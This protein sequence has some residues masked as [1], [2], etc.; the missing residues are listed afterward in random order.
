MPLLRWMGSF[1]EALR[2]SPVRLRRAVAML[3]QVDD[4]LYELGV[5]AERR[6]GPSRSL[7]ASKRL[8]EFFF[9]FFFCEL[10]FFLEAHPSLSEGL[11]S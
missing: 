5:A 6:L 8:G 3:W 9:F 4:L 11:G 10:S 7:G 1:L 2:D